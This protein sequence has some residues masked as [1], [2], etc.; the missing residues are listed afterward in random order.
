MEAASSRSHRRTPSAGLHRRPP[1]PLEGSK[2]CWSAACKHQIGSFEC[3]FDVQ[4]LVTAPNGAQ[5]WQ[6]WSSSQGHFGEGCR[7]E[8]LLSFAWRQ[9]RQ[10][11]ADAQLQLLS[12][13]EHVVQWCSRRHICCPLLPAAFE[14][15]KKSPAADPF[16]SLSRVDL[17]RGLFAFLASV[18]LRGHTEDLREG[19][20]CVSKTA[21]APLGL[22]GRDVGL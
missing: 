5:C 8:K 21:L 16:Y 10:L 15:R 7:A 6:L 12:S 22:T 2:A 1:R 9:H 20:H 18:T 17:P 14:R 4:P 13:S 11:A 19:R 3:S